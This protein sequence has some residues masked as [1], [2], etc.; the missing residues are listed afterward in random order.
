MQ[1]EASEAIVRGL[2]AAG[3]DLFSHQSG[4]R[5]PPRIALPDKGRALQID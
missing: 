1:G 4:E 2:K 5:L 3:G